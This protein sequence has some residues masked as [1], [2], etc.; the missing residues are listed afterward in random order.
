[1]NKVILE[2]KL[3]DG[4]GETVSQFI[5][6]TPV[7]PRKY[8]KLYYFPDTEVPM[9]FLNAMLLASDKSS[10]YLCLYFDTFRLV[11]CLDGVS[12]PTI[13]KYIRLLCEC[14]FLLKVKRGTYLINPGYIHIGSSYGTSD[15]VAKFDALMRK[16]YVDEGRKP[17]EYVSIWDMKKKKWGNAL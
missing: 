15:A 12:R 7:R 6:H 2:R 4:N 10:E 13:Q 1:M 17:D 3:T 5:V 16:K 8:Y 9:Y 11:D 14:E